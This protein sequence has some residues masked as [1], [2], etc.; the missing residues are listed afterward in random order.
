MNKDGLSCSLRLCLLKRTLWYRCFPANVEKHLT[1]ILQFSW[2][3]NLI[4]QNQSFTDFLKIG[5]FK[6]FAMFTEKNL[7]RNFFLMTP[8]NCSLVF[9]V[10]QDSSTGVS[11]DYWQT[12]KNSFF[13]ENFRWLLLIIRFMNICYLKFQTTSVFYWLKWLNFLVHEANWFC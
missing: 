9:W 3:N 8:Y 2:M 12:F 10:K 6:I 11:S 1:T 5:L 7:Y 13:I 4:I